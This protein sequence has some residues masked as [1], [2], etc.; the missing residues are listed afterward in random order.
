MR[1]TLCITKRAADICK[2]L[3]FV[4][5][6]TG[7]GIFVCADNPSISKPFWEGDT[8]YGESLVFIRKGDNPPLSTCLFNP[9]EIIEIRSTFKDI[10]Y[11]PGKDYKLKPGLREIYLP[12]DSRIQFIESDSL[13]PPLGAKDSIKYKADDKTRGVLFYRLTGFPEIQVEITYK[14]AE[15][16]NGVTPEFVGDKL[17]GFYGKLKKHDAVR[18]TIIGDSITSGYNASKIVEIPPY[19]PDWTV[20]WKDAM[21]QTFQT[22]IVCSVKSAPGRTIG[23]MLLNMDEQLEIQADLVIIAFGM[24]DY[25]AYKSADLFKKKLQEMLLKFLAKNPECEFLLISPMLGNPEW[26]NTPWPLAFSYLEAMK[27]IE[28]RVVVA[29]LT[30]LWFDM[31]EYKN[32]V[33]LSGNGVN[34]PNDFGHRIY[35]QYLLGMFL[36]NGPVRLDEKAAGMDVPL[37]CK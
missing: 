24:N 34:H 16:W 15:K 7:C 13:F 18:V 1:N 21:M 35:A 28:G 3:L 20:L 12:P 31:L 17:P 6:L 4:I 19:Q 23:W 10:V 29:D 33:S 32:Y 22:P 37:I 36:N 5:F 8:V 30:S 26:S 25:D 14:H 9:A 11:T 2:L 27:E